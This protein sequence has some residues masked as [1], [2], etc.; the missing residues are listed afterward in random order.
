MEEG[1]IQGDGNDD[2]TPDSE[3]ADVISVPIRDTETVSVDPNAPVVWATLVGNSAN[4]ADSSPTPG[5]GVIVTT[6]TQSDAPAAEERDGIAMPLGL[7]AFAAQ[8]EVEDGAEDAG[9]IPFSLLIE[10]DIQ[11]NDFWKQNGDG[12]WVN[13]A[14]PEYGGQVTQ[15]GSM[16]VGV[17]NAAAH[18]GNW[19]GS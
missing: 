4:G 15:I 3:Q 13:L 18:G 14:S 12:D 17:P 19:G 6:L 8:A 16:M 2:G 11:V 10:G 5:G 1:G 9:D 7:I